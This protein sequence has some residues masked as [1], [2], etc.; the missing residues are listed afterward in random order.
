MRTRGENETR[1]FGNQLLQRILT[2]VEVMDARLQR[3]ESR[4]EGRAFDT[5]PIWEQA[6][7]GIM[8]IHLELATVDRKID[9]FSSAC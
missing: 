6:L 2:K 7:A 9:V 5:K 3:V 4:V 1:L 8:E